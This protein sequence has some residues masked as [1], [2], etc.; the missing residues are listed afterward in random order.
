[1]KKIIYH[2]LLSSLLVVAHGFAAESSDPKSD[3]KSVKGP[4]PI[5]QDVLYLGPDHVIKQGV[6]HL[7]YTIDEKGRTTQ[8][9]VL[10]SNNNKLNKYAVRMVGKWRYS[11][12]LVDGEPVATEVILPVVFESV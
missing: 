6:V 5:H 2:L 1:M 9:E 7:K 4:V 11:P 12:A 10:Q 3:V 8:I